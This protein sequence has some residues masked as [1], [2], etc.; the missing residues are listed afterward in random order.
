MADEILR[1]A[2]RAI[3]DLRKLATVL[4]DSG[5]PASAIRLHG[6]AGLLKSIEGELV[7]AQTKMDASSIREG[8]D[9]TPICI[10]DTPCLPTRSALAREK[11]PSF[12][13][14]CGMGQS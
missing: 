9:A 10:A 5:Y 13:L 7:D 1:R 6:F 12:A 4:N 14:D 8:E 2:A 11:T 3:T